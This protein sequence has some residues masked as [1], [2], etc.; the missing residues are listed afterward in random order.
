MKPLFLFHL[1]SLCFMLYA[2]NLFSLLYSLYSLIS[3]LLSPLSILLSLLSV[4]HR[5]C[6][7]TRIIQLIPILVIHLDFECIHDVLDTVFLE[8]TN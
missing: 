1:Y 7:T 6:R 4:Q 5:R 3:T 2:L 8:R